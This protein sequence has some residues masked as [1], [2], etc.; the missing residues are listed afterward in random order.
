MP[1]LLLWVVLFSCQFAGLPAQ[2]EPVE[3]SHSITASE[4]QVVKIA[5]PAYAFGVRVSE[6]GGEPLFTLNSSAEHYPVEWL[7]LP[8]SQSGQYVITLSVSPEDSQYSQH[9]ISITPMTYHSATVELLTQ[10]Q[11]ISSRGG[12]AQ[13]Q[14]KGLEQLASQHPIAL[15]RHAQMLHYAGK[16]SQSNRLL[17]Q[18]N[19]QALAH[20]SPQLVLQQRLL[21]SQ[22][23]IALNQYQQALSDVEQ[24]LQYWHWVNSQRRLSAVGLAEARLTLAYILAHIDVQQNDVLFN[25]LETVCEASVAQQQ[26][27]QQKSKSAHAL[28]SCLLDNITAQFALQRSPKLAFSYFKNRWLYFNAL[29]DHAQTQATATEALQQ[30][31][32]IWST[33]QGAV[34]HQFL[35]HSYYRNGELSKGLDQYRKSLEG[36]LSAQDK[37][38]TIYTQHELQSNTADSYFNIAFLYNKI[39]EYKRAIGYFERSAHLRSQLA[40]HSGARVAQSYRASAMRAVGDTQQ[41]AEVHAAVVQE[42][43]RENYYFLTTSIELAFDYVQ[44]QQWQKAT[45]ILDSL[46]T[47]SKV[48]TP[49][50]IDMKL[51]EMHSALGQQNIDNASKMESQLKRIFAS[52]TQ[53]AGRNSYLLRHLQ[54]Y[55]LQMQKSLSLKNLQTLDNQYQQAQQLIASAKITLR[56]TLAFTQATHRIIQRYIDAR[57]SITGDTDQAALAQIFNTLDSYYTANFS[58]AK[59]SRQLPQA[60]VAP[61][62][63][64]ANASLAQQLWQQ[65]VAAEKRAILS[66]NNDARQE[67]IDEAA[68]LHDRISAYAM[69]NPSNSVSIPK[70]SIA[71][72]QQK[73]QDNQSIALYFHSPLRSF[74]LFLDNT[75]LSLKPISHTARMQQLIE[76]ISAGKGLN[77]PM[78]QTDIGFLLPDNSEPHSPQT[79]KRKLFVVADSP[80]DKLPLDIINIATRDDHYRPAR[81]QYEFVQVFSPSLY[82]ADSYAKTSLSPT[83]NAIDIAIF[84]NPIIDRDNFDKP[85]E[86]SQYDTWRSGLSN[87]PYTQVEAQRIQSLFTQKNVQVFSGELATNATLMAENVRA[88]SILHI[89][90]HGYYDPLAPEIVAFATTS[91]KANANQSHDFVTLTELHSQPFNSQLVVVSGCE[92]LLGQ[93]YGGT[94]MNGLSRNFLLQGAGS[95]IGTL[96]KIPDKPTAQFMAY[97]YQALKQNSGDSSAALF[98]AKNRLAQSGRYRA[99]VYWAGFVLMASHQ[100]YSNISI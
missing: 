83:T 46:A 64:N 92:T 34:F 28:A 94:G 84:A 62:S 45:A 79:V 31:G 60:G 76:D 49:Q 87:L 19:H 91:S 88:A 96:W 53:Q 78:D 24:Y 3:L 82:F 51:I 41:A 63:Q 18:L 66:S 26:N 5:G 33:S 37:P 13:E 48:Y 59:Q 93:D 43:S 95:V 75:G 86:E 11:T 2:A 39:G 61:A 7:Y 16:F 10:L 9:L 27:G 15:L 40:N 22:N 17:T 67:A 12:S 90:T 29:N 47:I 8:A 100:Q 77:T 73:L 68:L 35:G 98:E 81:S 85:G 21:S 36:F 80:Y 54:F 1:R 74:A 44:L 30:F 72:L 32:A 70:L 25:N 52:N 20:A 4:Q 56:N 6:A 71:T 69:T 50:R 23:H 38:S 57:L 99:P 58:S 65:K 42:L 14:S 97:F 89:A 55:D